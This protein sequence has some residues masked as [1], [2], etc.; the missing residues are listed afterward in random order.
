[1]ARRD[2]LRDIG[3]LDEDFPLY[4]VDTDWCRRAKAKGWQVW[5]D[6]G[7]SIIH[8]EHKGGTRVNRTQAIRMAMLMHRAAYRYYCKAHP[9]GAALP[10]RMVALVGLG[11]K[12]ALA[13]SKEV[14]RGHPA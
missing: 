9:R 5:Y 2:V 12:A 13:I 11:M 14:L 8:Y 1:M 10:M 7:A 3:L 4:F 6:P